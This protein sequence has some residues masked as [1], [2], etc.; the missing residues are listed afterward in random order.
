MGPGRVGFW[1]AGALSPPGPRASVHERGREHVR[2]EAGE[3]TNALTLTHELDRE[4]GA[5]LHR[6]P[7]CDRWATGYDYIASRFGAAMGAGAAKAAT[8]VV[9]P[10][11]R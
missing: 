11:L 4:S 8:S 3:I 9:V 7:W 2:R 5:L 6:D 1:A 10:Q